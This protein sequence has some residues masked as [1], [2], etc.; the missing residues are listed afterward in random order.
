MSR[1]IITIFE[2]ELREKE[3]LNKQIIALCDDVKTVGS[4]Y[5]YQ[6]SSGKLFEIITMLKLGSISY[7]THFDT[8]AIVGSGK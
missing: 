8:M 3:Y 5:A 2:E 1:V 4:A 7:G 6:P